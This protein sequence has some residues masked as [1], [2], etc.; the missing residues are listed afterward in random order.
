MLYRPKYWAK[1]VFLISLFLFSPVSIGDTRGVENNNPANI[2]K[3]KIKWQGKVECPDPRFECFTSPFWGL[4]AM[5][6]NLLTYYEHKDLD[7]LR[8]IIHR[9]SPPHENETDRI[10]EDVAA[11]LGVG[12]DERIP[13]NSHFWYNLGVE[14]ILQEN[15]FNPYPPTLIRSAMNHAIRDFNDAGVNPPRRVI[16]TMVYAYTSKG[17]ATKSVDRESHTTGR[18]VEGSQRG[19][20]RGICFYTKGNSNIISI[21][22]NRVASPSTSDRTGNIGSVRMDRMDEWL[23]LLYRWTRCDAMERDDRISYWSSP[24]TSGLSNKWAILRRK[25]CRSSLKTEYSLVI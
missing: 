24:H 14:I 4:R 16:E 17:P 7:T 10:I 5:Y 25:Y 15:G 22:Y 11:T 23:S 20:K 8:E 13:F 6:R 21:R 2:V 3:T 12:P 9:W 1:G 18:V 19:E